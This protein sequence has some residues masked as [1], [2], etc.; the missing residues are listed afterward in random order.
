MDANSEILDG[1][2]PHN[3][4]AE[5]GVLGSIL[6]DPN[7]ADDVSLLLRPD[8]FYAE[9][10]EK[11]YGHLLKMNDDGICIDATLLLERLRK[12]GDLTAVGGA[13]YIGECLHSVPYA[14]N[15]VYYAKIVRQKSIL[16]KIIHATTEILRDA[17]EP[18]EEP[19]VILDRAEQSLQAITD[20]G[21]CEFQT[22][23]QLAIEV[24]GHIDAVC[25][26]GKHL[27]LSTG[28]QEFD[29]RN[30]GLFGGELVIL[31]ARPSVGKSALAAQIADHVAASDRKVYVASLE[32]TGR[33]LAQRTI[34]SLAGVSGFAVRA[35]RLGPSDRTSLS[36]GMNQYARRRLIV[37]CRSDLTVE[38]LART[39]RRQVRD[40][41]QLAVID[42]LGLLRAS[43]PKLPRYEQVSQQT[44]AL[45]LLA[46]ETGIVLMVL[47][48]LNRAAA[49]EH[50]A[51]QLHNLRE[52]G[53]IEQDA[54]TVLFIHRPEDGIML[55]DPNN[56]RAKIK[57]DWPAE[58][59]VAKQRNGA[60][61]RI[62]LDWEAQYTRF[63]CW[64]NRYSEPSS[65]AN[66]ESAFDDFSGQ[67]EMEF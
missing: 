52:S 7:V 15:A 14:T 21:H 65:M 42:Y 22:A 28:L 24:G 56:K 47:C 41:L 31:A 34:C 37:D 32:M 5:K 25:E 49:E 48:Q 4:E 35:G 10:N 43:N 51:P 45:K 60:T 20:R 17:Y 54:D 13:A 23:E 6:L 9:A 53:S 58:L 66:Y 26:Q 16:R 63:S 39:I 1:L 55:P 29:E 40:G 57:A 59:L 61:G 64:N 50:A 11:L 38:A 33:E 8:D 19:Q 18:T 30:G 36:E 12:A 46:R 44:R 67:K 2:P 3:I 62:K 27:G